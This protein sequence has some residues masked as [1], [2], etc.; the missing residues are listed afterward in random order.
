[1]VAYVHIEYSTYQFSEESKGGGIHPPPG[2]CGTKNSVKNQRNEN[3][4]K[5]K[6]YTGGKQTYHIYFDFLQD[7]LTMTIRNIYS[8]ISRNL[9]L[10]H[11]GVASDQ[12]FKK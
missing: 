10:H 9:R 5:N 1:M 11:D 3:Y 2:P 12:T 8:S 7:C 6:T 4:A